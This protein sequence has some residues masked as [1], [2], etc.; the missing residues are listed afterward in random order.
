MTKIN[1]CDIRDEAT[2]RLYVDCRHTDDP[3]V[4]DPKRPVRSDSGVFRMN[5]SQVDVQKAL[6]EIPRLRREV[7]I[8]REVFEATQVPDQTMGRPRKVSI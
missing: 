1:S 2:G 6:E 3:T 8:L 5:R 7:Q 4:Y